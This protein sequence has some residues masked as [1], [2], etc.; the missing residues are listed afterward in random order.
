MARLEE[1][2]AS[3][4]RQVYCALAFGEPALVKRGGRAVR[5]LLENFTM[6]QMI[7]LS[8]NF[9]QYTSLEWSIDWREIDISSMRGWFESEKDYV[10]TLILGSFHPNGYYRE[11]CLREMSAYDGTLAY[12]VLRLN[13]WVEPVRQ[14]AYR[15]A[16]DRLADC[17]LE[18]LFAAMMALDKV[19]GSGRRDSGKLAEIEQIIDDRLEHGAAEIE[20]ES[21]LGMEYAVRKSIYHYLMSGARLKRQTAETLLA[22]E[23]HSFCQ[24]LIISGLLAHYDCPAQTVERYMRHSSACVRQRAMEYQYA[25]LGC[26]WAGLKD[27]LLD[28]S[29]NIRDMAAYI[30]RKHSDVDIPAFYREHLSEGCPVTAILGIGEQG[31]RNMA[32]LVMPFLSHEDGRVVKSAIEAL[33]R[34]MGPAGEEIFWNCLFDPRACVSRASYLCIRKN[35][36]H[37][38]AEILDERQKRQAVLAGRSHMAKGTGK[39]GARGGTARKDV[40]GGRNFLHH[41]RRYLIL[42]LLREPSWERLPFLIYLYRDPSAE[43]LKEKILGAIGTRSL[44][45][46]ISRNQA[47]MIRQALDEEREGLPEKLAEEILFDMKFVV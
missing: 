18:E 3:C 46:R 40:G 15:V 20:P 21:I 17:P 34:L 7:R 8:E 35:G 45:T 31:S 42:L 13:D 32:D 5:V 10:Y 1:M 29:Y 24:R 16:G 39:S 28:A 33:D 36:I 23:R 4:L 44:Y 41:V 26:A 25:V 14:L 22:R 11:A 37:Y 9:R 19:K 30:L 43:E 38:G 6:Q 47:D 2:D 27:M 12:I